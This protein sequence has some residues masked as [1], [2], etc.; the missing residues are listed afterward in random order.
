MKDLHGM[1]FSCVSPATVNAFNIYAREWISYGPRVR[2]IF[3]AADEDEGCCLV[4][5]HAACVHMALESAS[6][7]RSASS[8]GCTARS[9]T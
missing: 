1:E 9:R 8:W 3:E 2:S 5:A 6:G 7:F 4:S